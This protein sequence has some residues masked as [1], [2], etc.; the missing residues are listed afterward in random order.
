MG[1][2]LKLLVFL[3]I[4]NVIEKL[5][6]MENTR[7]TGNI[8]KEGL[9]ALENEYQRLIHSV[10]GL[11]FFLAFDAQ[12]SKLR[13]DLLNKL[14]KKGKRCKSFNKIVVNF[15]LIQ[16]CFSVIFRNPLW[17]KWSRDYYFATGSNI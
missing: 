1:D 16:N 7:T 8:L 5:N 13:E 15:L 17:K 10:R 12:C 4:I 14:R 9:Y 6:L 11:G 2:P 3:T